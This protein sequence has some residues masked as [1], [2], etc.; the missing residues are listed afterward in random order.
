MISRGCSAERERTA[1][2]GSSKRRGLFFRR[3]SIVGPSRH[4]GGSGMNAT[5]RVSCAGRHVL[6]W[7]VKDLADC[8]IAHLS[9][10]EL[11]LTL[12]VFRTQAD[13]VFAILG[14]TLPALGAA[15]AD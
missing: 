3:V 14:E 1:P 10:E 13:R 15:P 11:E 6:D 4:M 9:R 8:A 12:R 5:H 2:V 7:S